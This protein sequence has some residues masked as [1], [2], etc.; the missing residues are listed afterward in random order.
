M[1]AKLESIPGWVW[2]ANAHKW[3]EKFSE[4]KDLAEAGH[5]GELTYSPKDK[6]LQILSRWVRYNRKG[7][8][9]KNNIQMTPERKKK[10]ESIPGWAWEGK[11]GD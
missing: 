2:D 9:N 8:K 7:F 10:L 1:V 5:L 3:E 4:L 11:L 6:S